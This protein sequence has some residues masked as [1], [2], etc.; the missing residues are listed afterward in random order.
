MPQVSSGAL[1]LTLLST[2]VLSHCCAIVL[3]LYCRTVPLLC[4]THGQVLISNYCT[5]LIISPRRPHRPW[6]HTFGRPTASMT[7]PFRHNLFMLL[8]VTAA[9]WTVCS[10]SQRATYCTRRFN[11]TTSFAA[12]TAGTKYSVSG[13]SCSPQLRQTDELAC[14]FSPADEPDPDILRANFGGGRAGG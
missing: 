14:I 12:V 8:L 9:C 10:A 7:P 13:C 4:V 6:A 5:V 3:L 11:V 1:Y 2:V